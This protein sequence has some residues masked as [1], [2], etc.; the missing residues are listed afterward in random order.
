[1]LAIRRLTNPISESYHPN[2][3]GHASGYAP[4]VSPL[5]TGAPFTVTGAVLQAARAQA[6][7]LAARQ[8]RYAE[9]DRTIKPERFGT[10]YAGAR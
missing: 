2:R 5:L 1:M 6:P 10:P 8:R 9:A 7:A 4:L 3:T